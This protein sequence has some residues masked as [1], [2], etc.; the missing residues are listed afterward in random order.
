[1]F[2]VCV[3]FMNFMYMFI[4]LACKVF[5]AR[6]CVLVFLLGRVWSQQ[7]PVQIGGTCWH[8]TELSHCYMA[9]VY[10]AY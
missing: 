8:L 4:Q 9:E 1:M 5:V 7:Q 2:Y 3:L 6:D 10:S